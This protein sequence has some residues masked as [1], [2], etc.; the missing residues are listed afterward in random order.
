M[1][2]RG[3]LG[4]IWCWPIPVWVVHQKNGH[5]NVGLDRSLASAVQSAVEVPPCMATMDAPPTLSKQESQH[6]MSMWNSW[7][8]KWNPTIMPNQTFVCSSE[9]VN[10]R[11]LFL[12]NTSITMTGG[13]DYKAYPLGMPST[14]YLASLIQ[15]KTYQHCGWCN[16]L[17]LNDKLV[18]DFW[19][20]GI[21]TR[22]IH[23]RCICF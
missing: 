11:R 20:F 5:V 22:E 18:T 10:C 9:G 3:T 21:Q 14:C 8:Q 17:F 19:S 15:R 1:S 2:N 4:R 16:F 23:N 7:K 6:W 13:N 12:K